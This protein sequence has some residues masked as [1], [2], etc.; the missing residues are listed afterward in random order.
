[1]H[2]KNPV[3]E[4]HDLTVSY[5]KKPAIW[6]VDFMIPEGKLVGIIGPNG[7]GKS[8]LIKAMMQLIPHD[9]GFTKLF[10]KELD[11]VRDKVAYVP[12][13][14]SVDWDFP[15]S[16]SDVV[17]MGRYGKRGIFNRL[18]SDDKKIAMECLEK[19]GMQQF[20]HR[21]ISQLSGGQ[22][23]RVFI[24]RSLAQQ[25]DLYFMDEPFAGI[26][27][28]TEQTIFELLLNMRSEGKTILVVHHDLQ[29]AYE[30]FDWI[31]LLNTQLIAAGPKEEIF[32]PEYLQK[33]YG[34][35]LSLLMNVGQLL[36]EM[37]A[38]LREKK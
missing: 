36:S 23:Q 6:D 1:M 27:A 34:G 9:S 29:S 26:D 19:V 38:P 4:V 15:A 14:G 3:I 30:Y 31:I 12:Q 35:K 8:T 21:Q 25:A 18:K 22:Q 28:T 16:V 11:D 24:A 32:V 17:Q 20:I 5:N 37:E 7:A 33:T 10:G 13:R 2:I